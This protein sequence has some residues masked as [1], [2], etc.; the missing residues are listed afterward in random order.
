M[1]RMPLPFL[2]T[3]RWRVS[4]SRRFSAIL[5]VGAFGC[6]EPAPS[7]ADAS[8]VDASVE[9]PSRED[10]TAAAIRVADAW[11]ASQP[12]TSGLRARA[13]GTCTRDRANDRCLFRYFLGEGTW[14]LYEAAG[15]LRSFFFV[16]VNA[17]GSGL[18]ARFR[19]PS[20]GFQ[21]S[22]CGCRSAPGFE[23][24]EEYDGRER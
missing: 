1:A 12:G 11:V 23:V 16:E 18:R 3:E 10:E 2:C 21:W 15:R 14:V 5:L 4:L 20:I 19:R 6:R 9:L 13:I 17:S 24:S 8:P 7:Q 22:T